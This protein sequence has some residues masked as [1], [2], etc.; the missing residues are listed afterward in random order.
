MTEVYDFSNA[1][2]DE[3]LLLRSAPVETTN[4]KTKRNNGTIF[5]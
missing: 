3:G 4:Q 5:A 2:R 1:S